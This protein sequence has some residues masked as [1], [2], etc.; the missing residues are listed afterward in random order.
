[1]N[2]HFHGKE[3]LIFI[4]EALPDTHH[5]LGGRS[6]KLPHIHPWK[7]ERTGLV[8]PTFKDIL[9]T[10]LGCWGALMLWSYTGEWLIYW[11]TLL[12]KW[13]LPLSQELLVVSSFSATGGFSLL[14]G[15]CSSL[16]FHRVCVCCH[17]SSELEWLP[18]CAYR[19]PF[20]CFCRYSGNNNCPMNTC[21]LFP[22]TYEHDILKKKLWKYD[23]NYRL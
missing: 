17:T 19:I 2:I 13:S 7:Q 15:I 10:W 8:H 1:M 23:Y 18:G 4:S 21:A 5:C 22:E 3:N 20:S 9:K 16:G 12:R 14:A 11:A 6:S